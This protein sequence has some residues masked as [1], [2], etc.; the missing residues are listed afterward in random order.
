[1]KGSAT[2][3]CELCGSIRYRTRYQFEDVRLVRCMECGLLS[4]QILADEGDGKDP[5]DQAYYESRQ[6]YYFQNAVTNPEEGLENE[7]IADFKRGLALLEAYK[8]PRGSKLLDVGCALGIFLSLARERGWDPYGIDISRYAV[9]YA[10]TRFGICAARGELTDV[11]FPDREFDVI[12]L[13]DVFEHFRNPSAQLQEMHRVLKDDGVVLLDTPNAE[14][15]IRRISHLLY[16]VSLGKISYPARKLHHVF[17]L[18]YYS[19][20]TLRSIVRKHGFDIVWMR[21]KPIPLVKA[22]GSALERLIVKGFS[23][24]EKRLDMQYEILVLL[25]KAS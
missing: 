2:L 12:T 18:Y 11:R 4:V 17:H 6:D 16:G 21:G 13:W 8:N 24:L 23:A 9:E 25:R 7:N 3:P 22:R 1:V 14:A 5:Y 20:K 19:R 10:Q 15:L